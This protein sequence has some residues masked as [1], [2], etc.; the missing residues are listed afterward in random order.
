M[1]FEAGVDPY[2]SV[3]FQVNY[4]LTW[5]PNAPRNVNMATIECILPEFEPARLMK[6]EEKEKYGIEEI[7]INEIRNR[8]P[9]LGI[10]Q[11]KVDEFIKSGESVIYFAHKAPVKL[12][13]IKN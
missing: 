9:E 5:Y 8:A 11:E 7:P 4:K 13:T 1:W 3:S 2:Y 6:I 12:K 10:S